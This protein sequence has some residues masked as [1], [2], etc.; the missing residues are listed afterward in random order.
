MEV[1]PSQELL[2]RVRELRERGRTPKEIARALGLPPSEVAP[3]IREI[4][5][6]R[7][8]EEKEDALI[9]CLVSR[10]WAAGLTVKGHRDWPGVTDS[11]GSGMASVLIARQRRGKVYVCSYLIDTW[12]LGAKDAIPPTSTHRHP[13][14]EI[15]EMTFRSYGG[16]PLTAP[17]D[18]AQQLVFGAVEYARGLGFKPH[19]DYR[20]C[21][22]YLGDW[23][24]ACDITFGRDGQPTYIGG[25]YDDTARIL[26]TIRK[27]PS[28]RTGY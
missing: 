19:P 13:L 8:R 17:L 4:A 26:R 27:N 25:P 9:S 2:T 5:A 20:K 23:D 12:C 7:P 11:D 10:G 14:P 24:G 1:M 15:I 21:D 28:I 3:L 16:K 6:S 22:G 18:L